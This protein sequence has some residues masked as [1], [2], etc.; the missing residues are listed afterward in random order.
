VIRVGGEGGE[1]F[2]GEKANLASLNQK[3]W[4]GVK[5]R[6]S[7]SRDLRRK[8]RNSTRMQEKVMKT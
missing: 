8:E 1:E 5:F 4:G 6:K 2:K 3:K 7:H